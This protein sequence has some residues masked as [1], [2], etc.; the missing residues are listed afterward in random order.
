L[1]PTHFWRATFLTSDE[2]EVEGY[3][4]SD[5]PVRALEVL[6]AAAVKNNYSKF[7]FKK[8]EKVNGSLILD[9]KRNTD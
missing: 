5:N 2:R 3:I 7:A 9:D 6:M 1:K 8:F 4:E